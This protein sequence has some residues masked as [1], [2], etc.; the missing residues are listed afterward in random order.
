MELYRNVHQI[1]SLYG[2][3][4]LFQYLFIGKRLVLVDSGVAQTPGETIIPYI[5]ELGLD[6]SRL[7]MV[8]TT[9]PDG[10]HQGGNGAMREMAPSV[11]IACGEPDRRLVQDPLQL[12]EKRYNFLK[13]EHEVGCEDTPPRDAGIRC[14]V[15]IGLMGGEHVALAEDWELEVLHVP[16]HSAGHLALFDRRRRAAFVS[17]AVHGRGCPRA[18]GKMALPVTYF[19]IESYLST[20]SYLES[21]PLEALHTGH[22]PSMY[23]GEIKDFFSDSRQTVEILDRRILN[24]LHRHPQ[25]MT[26]NQLIEQAREEFPEWPQDTRDLTMF[27]VKAHLD[28]LEVNGQVRLMPNGYPRRWEHI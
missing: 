5:D 17:D 18:D 2:G 6:P 7:D 28:R 25:G 14:R 13:H 19:H 23:G 8:I 4:Y 12:Y 3:R 27:A 1:C 26:L 15:D 10:D 16:G 9:H 11:L 20:L 24:S 22:W 21:L